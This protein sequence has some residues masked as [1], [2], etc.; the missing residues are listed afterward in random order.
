[1]PKQSYD[2]DDDFHPRIANGQMPGATVT[3][4]SLRRVD[5]VTADFA[6]RIHAT[7]RE[8]DVMDS[9]AR[10]AAIVPL[11]EQYAEVAGGRR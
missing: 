5:R 10:V 8:G 2:L 4:D 3:P 7:W 6:A 1:M 9:G 11:L